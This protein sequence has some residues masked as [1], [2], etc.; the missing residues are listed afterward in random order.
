MYMYIRTNFTFC[1]LQAMTTYEYRYNYDSKG[2]AKSGFVY[3]N[4]TVNY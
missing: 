1:G 3:G 2:K 4:K